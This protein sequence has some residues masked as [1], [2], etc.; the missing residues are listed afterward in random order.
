MKF[1]KCLVFFLVIWCLTT[2]KVF[3]A[4]DPEAL[5]AQIEALKR[6]MAEMQAQMQAQI[7]ALQKK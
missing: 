6:Q 2:V 5:K 7:E 4:E 3:A 1:L